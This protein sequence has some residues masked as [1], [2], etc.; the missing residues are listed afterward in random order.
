MTHRD[1]QIRLA[2]ERCNALADEIISLRRSVDFL[3]DRK[4]A[5]DL[6]L[7][8][9]HHDLMEHDRLIDRVRPYMASTLWGRLR[10]LVTGS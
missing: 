4:T 8:L 7:G 6:E 9:L 10:A 5:H 3:E 2:L 1:Q